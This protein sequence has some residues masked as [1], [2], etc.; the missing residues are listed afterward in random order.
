MTTSRIELLR[1]SVDK[2]IRVRCRDGESFVGKILSVSAD[3]RDLVYD[4]VSTSR[5]SLYEK[6]DPQPAYLVT[7]DDIESVAVHE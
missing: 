4:L 2:L 3:K 1:A 5:E 7:F 6:A